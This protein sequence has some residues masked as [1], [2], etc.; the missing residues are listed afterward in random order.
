MRR[1]LLMLALF[2]VVPAA[3]AVTFPVKIIVEDSAGA[4]VEN[5]LLV[6]VQDLDNGSMRLFEA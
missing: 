4:V 3:A 2:D 6:I 5:E 1:L